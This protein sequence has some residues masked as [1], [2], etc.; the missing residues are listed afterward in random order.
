MKKTL[1]K[2]ELSYLNNLRSPEINKFERAQIMADS[3]QRRRLSG[4][5]LGNLLGVP[6]STIEDWL[7]FS[8]LSL[9]QYK[10]MK[11]KGLG[12]TQI[13]RQLRNKDKKIAYS[14]LTGLDLTLQNVLIQL[15]PYSDS[16]S[17]QSK[18]TTKLID[19]IYKT[20][21]FI[22]SNKKNKKNE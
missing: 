18:T 10:G 15:K 20:L 22:K 4:R 1:E 8:K 16:R 12:D 19:E 11:R 14:Y 17:S 3:M 2:L 5:A 7:L 21:K 9:I 13:Y 6:K